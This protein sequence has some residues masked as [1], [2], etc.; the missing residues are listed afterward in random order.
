MEPSGPAAQP[1]ARPP[2]PRPQVIELQRERR[3]G[4]DVIV[5][6]GFPG[7]VD[8]E[9]L[10]RAF[11]TRCGA[12]GTV[13]GREIEIQGDHREVLSAMLLERGFRSKRCGG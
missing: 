6:R 4:R 10:A 8:V 2:K 7:D 9:A 13:K 3:R 1:E 5:V 11:K 12:G